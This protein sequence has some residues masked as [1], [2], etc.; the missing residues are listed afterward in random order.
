MWEQ[1]PD[2]V[3]MK[4]HD[5]SQKHLFLN[6]LNMELRQQVLVIKKTLTG[7]CQQVPD[8]IIVTSHGIFNLFVI[9]LKI[10]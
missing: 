2:D 3:T 1:V 4:S 9:F 5:I 10:F 6:G 8:D 7:M